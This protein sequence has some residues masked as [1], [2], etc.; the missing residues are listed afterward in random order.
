MPYTSRWLD[1]RCP[2]GNAPRSSARA[3]AVP[4]YRSV[5]SFDVLFSLSPC[6]MLSKWSVVVGAA[7]SFARTGRVKVSLPLPNPERR[8]LAFRGQV[9]H[10]E[11]QRSL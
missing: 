1:T 10:F 9:A 2:G 4:I 8:P 5:V 11:S 7:D 6:T 3:T